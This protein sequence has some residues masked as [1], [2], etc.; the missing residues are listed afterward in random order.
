[1]AY[2]PAYRDGMSE[3]GPFSPDASAAQHRAQSPRTVRAAVVTISDTRTPETDESGRYLAG[4]LRAAGHTVVETLIVPDDAVPIRSAL[5]RLMRGCDV[6]I[7][8]GGTGIAGRDVTVP[9]VESLLTKPIPGFGEL[10]RMLSYA[11]VGGAAMLS[12]A[13]GG[14]GRG[15]LLFALPGSLNAVRTAWEGLLAP[16]LGHL[17]HEMVR[18]G[19]PGAALASASYGAGASAPSPADPARQIGRHTLRPATNEPSSTLY[20]GDQQRREERGQDE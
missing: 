15:S 9:V 11:Q 3:P 17:V 19:Q 7:T 13:V 20:P 5:V 16:E 1:M 4:E 12:R 6:V 14:L 10:F 2:R 18:Q 8:S